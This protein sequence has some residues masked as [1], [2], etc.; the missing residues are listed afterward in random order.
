MAI[1]VV[2]IFPAIQGE[3]PVAGI[4]TVFVRTG[5]CDHRCGLNRLTGEWTMP[6]RCDSLHAVLPEHSAAWERLAPEE[7][8]ARVREVSGDMP[9]MVTLSGGNPALH[10]DI[11]R[12]ID[13]GH[14]DGYTFAIETQGTVRPMWLD[15]LDH[16]VVSPKPPSSGVDTDISELIVFVRAVPQATP[17]AIKIVVA[18]DD[19]L[20]W[21][22]SVFDLFAEVEHFVQPCN[23]DPGSDDD[24][25]VIQGALDAYRWLCGEL[26]HRRMYRVR[27]LPQ[28]HV[29]AHANARGV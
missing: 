25:S 9:I 8:M 3:G 23:L 14:E 11:G 4:P 22:E 5:G 1:S 7:V 12:L 17:L 20:D 27:A 2:E 15:Q 6:F 16:V 21:A 24:E 19:D 28:L 29:L 26:M 10:R 13:L 18:N